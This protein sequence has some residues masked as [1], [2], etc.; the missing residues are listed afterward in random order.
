MSL[1][2]AT[3][4]LLKWKDLK[5]HVLPFTSI[6]V[7]VMSFYAASVLIP[8][9]WTTY[10]I[11]TICLLLIAVT[12]LARVN[13]IPVGNISPR[14]QVRRLGLILVAAACVG[15]VFAPWVS[16]TTECALP[17]WRDVML[18]MGVTFTWMTT[19][20]MP[21]WNRYITGHYRKVQVE[22]ADDV[23]VDIVRSN[24]GGP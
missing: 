22:V 3:P 20:M 6:V 18:H 12:A 8:A 24:E 5:Q 9:G 4:L 15:M 23:R 11:S 19:P 17:E 7:F 2:M 1:Q 13:D 14:W 10:T 21:P 16:E